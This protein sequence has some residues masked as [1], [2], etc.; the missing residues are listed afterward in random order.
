M[1]NGEAKAL[2][3]ILCMDGG[4][5]RKHIIFIFWTVYGTGNEGPLHSDCAVDSA[6][7]TGAQAGQSAET[8]RGVAP[9]RAMWRENPCRQRRFTHEGILKWEKSDL[10]LIFRGSI[11]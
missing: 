9:S 7:Q 1:V 4:R 10:N 8:P 5:F 11:S 2:F 3:I 6:L